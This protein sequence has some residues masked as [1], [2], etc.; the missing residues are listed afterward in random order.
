MEWQFAVGIQLRS[1]GLGASGALQDSLLPVD[2]T[3]TQV[4][5]LTFR[6]TPQI[7][8][9]NAAMIKYSHF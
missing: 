2:Q 4:R 1:P 8:F 3:H 9:I 6:H 7:F 5:Q